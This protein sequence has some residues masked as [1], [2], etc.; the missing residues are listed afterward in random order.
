M[1][2]I[3]RY[4]YFDLH[5][6]WIGVRW[7]LTENDWGEAGKLTSRLLEIYI[8]VIPLFPIYFMIEVKTAND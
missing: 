5:D 7:S 4:W 3:K 2:L 8:C 6:F 1:R